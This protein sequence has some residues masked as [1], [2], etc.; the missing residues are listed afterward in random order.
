MRRP[1]SVLGAPSGIGIRPYDDG[2]PRH[3]SR[4]PAVLRELGL[5]A[6][7]GAYDMSDVIP[8]AYQDFTRPP[9]H[10]RNERGIA[11]YSHYLADG[12]AGGLAGGHFIVV[13]GGDCSIVL[14][15]LLGAR[16]CFGRVGLAYF[17]AHA[18]F[19]SPEESRTGSVA[20]MCLAL[21]VGRGDSA[22]AQ[23]GGATPLVRPEDVVLIGRR[24]ANQPG[25]GHAALRAS[26]ILD[27][28]EPALSASAATATI[29]TALGRM[30]RAE[31]GGF[32]IHVDA[33]VVDP[34]EMAAVDSPE[35]GGPGFDDLVTAI[36]PLVEHPKAL[37]MQVTLY[38]PLLDPDRSCGK[39][40]VSF[41]ESLLGSSTGGRGG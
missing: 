11:A 1:I 30:G 15:T 7:L 27:M 3:L 37:G 16:R 17:D 18:D 22:L 39:R 26:A 31:V 20:S 4:A 13:L 34:R 19:A 6:R 8:P 12:V 2:E 24:D 40:L 5:V 14:G 28:P 29:S 10:P 36:S 25:Y 32:W 9:A 38:D 33:D 35:P 41:L 21:A 23:L